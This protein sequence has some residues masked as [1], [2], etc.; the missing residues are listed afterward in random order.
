MEDRAVHQPSVCSWSLV[1]LASRF[2]ATLSPHAIRIPKGP[3]IIGDPLAQ[4]GTRWNPYGWNSNASLFFL[5]QPVGVGFSY[6][7]F[8]DTVAT[9]EEAAKDI[10]ALRVPLRLKVVQVLAGNC[11]KLSPSSSSPL[12]ILKGGRFIWLWSRMG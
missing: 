9:T 7:R 10:A 12:C 8:G 3:C 6:S 4:N 5:D 1:R 2:S 11:C